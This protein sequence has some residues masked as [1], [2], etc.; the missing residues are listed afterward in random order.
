[1]PHGTKGK[2]AHPWKTPLQKKFSS[3]GSGLTSQLPV[4]PLAGKDTGWG[5]P[6]LQKAFKDP[7]L[8]GSQNELTDFDG[9]SIRSGGNTMDGDGGGASTGPGGGGG[10]SGVNPLAGDKL[11]AL[12]NLE[13]RPTRRLGRKK[14][15]KGASRSRVY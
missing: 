8:V 11:T 10:G 2:G 7:N 9:K 13:T 14:S 5:V 4:Y 15:S 6:S 12:H 1:M 3:W